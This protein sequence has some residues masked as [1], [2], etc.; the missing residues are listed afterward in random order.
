MPMA[1]LASLGMA[2]VADCV[3]SV[4]RAAAGSVHTRLSQV[5]PMFTAIVLGCRVNGDDPSRCLEERLRTALELYRSGRAQRLLLSGDHGTRGYDEVNTMKDWL[6]SQ[7]VPEAHV[8]LDHAGFDTYDSMVRANKVFKVDDAIIV[9]QRFHLP[10]ALY[11]AR[12]AG[13]RAV[14][15]AADP[16]GG[17][18]CRGSAVREPLA[19]VKAVLDARLSLEPRFLGPPIPVHGDPSASFDRP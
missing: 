17:S 18:A 12:A 6:V 19:C 14:A 2:V 16:P 7:G 1:F 3:R 11:L 8:F 13:L 10:R 5:A 9:S 15:F 4:R